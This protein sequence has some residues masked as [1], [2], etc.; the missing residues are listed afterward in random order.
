MIIQRD[1]KSR[2]QAKFGG[3]TSYFGDKRVSNIL[4]NS[5]LQ[6]IN[7]MFVIVFFFF[8]FLCLKRFNCLLTQLVLD[9]FWKH[10]PVED[11]KFQQQLS[12]KFSSFKEFYDAF[13]EEKKSLWNWAWPW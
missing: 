2:F 11:S 8:I 1:C 9:R 13:L 5:V 10:C 6:D 7:D 3:A 4:I 12:A